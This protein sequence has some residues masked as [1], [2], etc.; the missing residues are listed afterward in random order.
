LRKYK[1]HLPEDSIHLKDGIKNGLS[2]LAFSYPYDMRITF[3]LLG[4]EGYS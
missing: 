3:E 4:E 1:W 2:P